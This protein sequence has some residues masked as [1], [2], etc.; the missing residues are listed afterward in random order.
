MLLMVPDGT[1]HKS[2]ERGLVSIVPQNEKTTQV[3]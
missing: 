3:D 2:Y 1:F